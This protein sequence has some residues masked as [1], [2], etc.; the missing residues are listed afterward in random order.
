MTDGELWSFLRSVMSQGSDIRADY[1]SGKWPNYEAYSARLDAAAAER[2]DQ[3][4]KKLGLS[5]IVDLR[6]DSERLQWLI[7]NYEDAELKPGPL[8]WDVW[9]TTFDQ[10]SVWLSGETARDAI[11]HAMQDAE[12]VRDNGTPYRRQCDAEESARADAAAR[13]NAA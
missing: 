7:D 5:E 6:K 10:E 12:D 11:D 1:D 8:G 2:A 9:V 3:L 13:S 4:A